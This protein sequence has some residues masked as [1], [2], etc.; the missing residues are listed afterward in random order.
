MTT[1]RF[2]C[3][4]YSTELVLKMELNCRIWYTCVKCLMIIGR[5]A[6]T[7]NS[8][9]NGLFARHR[10]IFGDRTKTG[11]QPYVLLSEFGHDHGVCM[12]RTNSASC[13]IMTVSK[14]LQGGK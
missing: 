5:Y 7:G 8:K 2:L 11:Y 13:N 9:R 14:T 4:A 10:I 1:K 12:N 6:F 3:C